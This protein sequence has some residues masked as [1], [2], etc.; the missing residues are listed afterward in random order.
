MLQLFQQTCGINTVMYY[1]PDI[2]IDSGVHF[3]NLPAGDPRTGIVFSIPLSLVNALGSLVV[4]FYID[5]L[6][7]RYIFLRCLPGITFS[8]IGVAFSMYLSGYYQKDSL[9]HEI[10]SFMALAFVIL[11][12]GFF[13]IGMSG[14]VWSVN[15][16]IYPIQLAGTANSLATATNWLSNFLV[17]SLFLTI[18]STKTGNVYAYLILASF[19]VSAWFFI[20]FL[21]PETNNKTI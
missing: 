2:I 21:L 16:E 8:L 20:Y 17:S 15:T 12:L 9:T 6:G 10:G 3:G 11:Y 5:K 4:I 7:R 13:S 19:S 18:T 1:G 14:T